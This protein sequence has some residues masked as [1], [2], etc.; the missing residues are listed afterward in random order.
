[1]QLFILEAIVDGFSSGEFDFANRL[2]AD[3]LQS[4]AFTSAIIDNIVDVLRSP[5]AGAALSVAGHSDRDDTV[6]RSHIEHL[7]VEKAAS[8]ARVI[9]AINHIHVLVQQQEPTAPSDLN[10]LS[11]FDVHLRSPGAGVLVEDGASLGEAQRK[12]NRRV[13]ARLL[14]FK[15]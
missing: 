1:M 14:V 4:A 13:Q 11:F 6:G 15:P 3:P 9:S 8:E 5:D 2:A 10:T 12:R 7:A